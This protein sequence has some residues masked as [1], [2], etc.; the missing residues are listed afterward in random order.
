MRLSI[1]STTP[2]SEGRTTFAFSGIE[3]EIFPHLKEEETKE[4][5]RF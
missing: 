4:I 3:T 5:A 2:F 1:T